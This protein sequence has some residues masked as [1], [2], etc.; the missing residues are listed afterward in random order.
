MGDAGSTFLGFTL[1]SLWVMADWSYH[2]SV[3]IA[4]P[5]L[6]LGVPILDM[7]MITVLRFKED[8]VSNFREWIEYTGKDHLSHRVM[9]L[10]LGKRGAVFVLWTLQAL[11]CGIALFI[12]PRGPAYGFA[13]L[14]FYFVLTAFVLFFFRRKR[15]VLLHLNGRRVKKRRHFSTV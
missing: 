8:K 1:S 10:G 6:I 7:V 15:R 9:R 4:I 12:L 2:W 11:L 14:F 13:G 3:R 5:M